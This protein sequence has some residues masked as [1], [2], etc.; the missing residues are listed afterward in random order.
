MSSYENSNC[1]TAH[2]YKNICDY[3]GDIPT[4]PYVPCKGHIFL[5][6]PW[7]DLKALQL[8]GL[9]EEYRI[10]RIYSSESNPINQKKLVE[11]TII[12]K[13]QV[14][15]VE[16]VQKGTSDKILLA[17][18]QSS[19]KFLMNVSSK[20]YDNIQISLRSD[21]ILLNNEKYTPKDIDHSILRD[22]VSELYIKDPCSLIML[23]VSMRKAENVDEIYKFRSSVTYN[24][25]QLQLIWSNRINAEACCQQKNF[26]EIC[27]TAVSTC[28]MLRQEALK[29]ILNFAHLC[30]LLIHCLDMD[31]VNLIEEIIELD[32][33]K[34]VQDINEC[35][36]YMNLRVIPRANCV[37]ELRELNIVKGEQF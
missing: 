17:I 34:T 14:K 26:A 15:L 3:F 22:L 27:E 37:N 35:P 7:T 29:N 24:P 33:G 12:K 2:S 9:C 6:Y 1:Q 18:N 31:F 13:A 36:K 10:L 19:F 5:L 30:A 21:N 4:C 11:F 25:D 8:K 20:K 32:S 16:L 23:M 28:T